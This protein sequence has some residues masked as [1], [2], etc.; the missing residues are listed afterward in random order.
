MTARLLAVHDQP[1]MRELLRYVLARAGHEVVVADSGPA[2]L[3][4][5]DSVLPHLVVAEEDMAGLSGL[6]LCRRVRDLPGFEWVPFL[7]LS[8]QRLPPVALA[9]LGPG[10]DAWLIEPFDRGELLERVAAVLERAR[11]H[12]RTSHIDPLT[13]LGDKHYLEQRLKEELYRQQ[14]YG[15]HSSLALVAIDLPTLDAVAARHGGAA[16][17]Q[18][19]RFVGRLLR[20]CMRELD[21]PAR[22]NDTGFLVL[23]PHTPRD[24]ADLA[25]TRLRERLAGEVVEVAGAPLP[26]EIS[27]GVTTLEAETTDLP[28]LLE[29][30][31][32]SLDLA[33]HEA[34]VAGAALATGRAEGDVTDG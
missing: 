17:D 24:G 13:A 6:E 23:M 9:E 22:Y 21:V 12:H 25:I 20:E 34:V 28:V 26:I 5:L 8:T 1:A 3:A 33:R 15:V 4:L 14:R 16:R 32:A 27:F 11:H 7:F 2:A 10:F 29:R 30:A 31:H 19:V 18:V